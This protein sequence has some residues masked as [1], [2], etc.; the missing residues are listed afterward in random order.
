MKS[1]DGLYPWDRN[2]FF[3]QQK[4]P[5]NDPANTYFFAQF[6]MAI[7][8]NEKILPLPETLACQ[9]GIPHLP[10]Y[11]HFA[12]IVL[13]RII[14]RGMEFQGI[15]SIKIITNPSLFTVTSMKAN[16]AKREL[17]V[18]LNHCANMECMVMGTS[19]ARCAGCSV[20]LSIELFARSSPS[21]D[22][23]LTIYFLILSPM[24]RS[25]P[26][27]AKSVKRRIGKASINRSAENIKRCTSLS[28]MRLIS[29][30]YSIEETSALTTDIPSPFFLKALNANHHC[31]RGGS[32]VHHAC[33]LRRYPMRHYQSH[34]FAHAKFQLSLSSTLCLVL[35]S[36]DATL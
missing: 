5:I 2:H 25:L 19:H 29:K 26:T 33:V 30:R 36:R 20:S 27:A 1:P 34:I 12:D 6:L 23:L 4:P 21:V 14:E 24:I 16:N 28:R 15:N 31:R 32:A 22:L 11:I 18:E 7:T 10:G 9:K 3:R 17:K 8:S 35:L 13:Y